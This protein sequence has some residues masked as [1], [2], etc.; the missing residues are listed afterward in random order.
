MNELTNDLHKEIERDLNVKLPNK[1]QGF[2]QQGSKG[3]T[4]TT[5]IDETIADLQMTIRIL[6]E[7]K[8]RL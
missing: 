4:H 7:A 8:R 2:Q 1:T 5:R 3:P 6:E